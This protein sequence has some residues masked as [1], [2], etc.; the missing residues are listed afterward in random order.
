[1]IK[2]LF[3]LVL[4]YFISTVSVIS[5]IISKIEVSGNKRISKE[6]VIVFSDLKI[7]MDY[8]NEL[9]NQSLK[10]LYSTNFIDLF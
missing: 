2:L 8:S 9:I 4:V 10:K 7:G 1:M 6:S 3:K 5:Q